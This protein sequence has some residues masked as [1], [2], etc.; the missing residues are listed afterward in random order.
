MSISI[1]HKLSVALL[2]ATLLVV[3]FMGLVIQWGFDKGFLEYI[4]KEEQVEIQRLAEKLEE[5]YAEHL[6]WNGLAGHPEEVLI[7]HAE[8]L[9]LE[10]SRHR[11]NELIE[12][13]R[14]LKN[15]GKTSQDDTNEHRRHPI[16]R[17]VIL[18][19]AGNILYGDKLEPK[20][21]HL[22]PLMYNGNRVGS[23]GLYL[24]R[25]LSES[26][27]VTFVEKQT[28]FLLMAILT[29]VVV[30]IVISMLLAYNLARPIRRLSSAAG[31]L[32]EGDY[33]VRVK[34]GSRDELARL[35]Q[36]FNT[37]A[38][39][40]EENDLQRKRWVSDIAHE[41]RTPL[42]SLK[43]QIEA[44]QDGI[45]KPDQR[46]YDILYKGV[47][48]LERLVE[49]L[50][51]LNRS[52]LG[53]F[54]LIQKKVMFNQLVETE[55][56]T[57][58][59]DAEQAGL[60]L[61]MTDSTTLLMVNGDAQRLQQLIGNLVTNSIRYTDHGGEIRVVLNQAD[62]HAVLKVADSEPGVADA[63][64]PRL[65]NRLYRVEESRNRSLGGSGLGLA[66]CREIVLAHG[67]T[68]E[69]RHSELGGLLVIAAIPLLTDEK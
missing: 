67:G 36:D 47:G 65:F 62:S 38:T 23:I 55:V 56:S 66:I 39:T 22:S 37:L 40:L 57:L 18:D 26:N 19:A 16:Q 45:R 14:H 44:L 28:T 8:I 10:K 42:T 31:K 17:T 52:D 7:L 21:P 50:Y 27:Q 46:T 51:D 11:L 69:A 59:G 1:F 24:P 29:S 35:S 60:K 13:E 5:Y 34:A 58:R 49:D 33:S 54:S 32:N 61:S 4:N 6:S 3:I 48:R 63:D 43:G 2:S 64:L 20:L 9:P 15:P 68:L 30:A 25:K 53:T 12:K 41:L